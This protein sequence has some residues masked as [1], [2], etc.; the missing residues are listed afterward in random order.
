MNEITKL[1]DPV[2]RHVGQE[3]S[4][5]RRQLLRFALGDNL[6]GIPIESVREILQVGVMTQVPMMP[7]FVRGVM[8]LRGAV[9]PVLDLGLRLGLQATRISRRTCIVIVETFNVEGSA[10]RHGV[11]VDAVHEVL[12]VTHEQINSVPPL[13]TRVAPHFIA[14]VTRVHEQSVEVLEVPRVFDDIELSRLVEEHCDQ[15]RWLH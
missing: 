8:N 4:E 11:L 9:V 1:M 2:A 12:E 3:A 7:S 14:G 10:Q 5:E 15:S 6:Y 13:G